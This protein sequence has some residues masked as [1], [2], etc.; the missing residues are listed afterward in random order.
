MLVALAAR[1]PAAPKPPEP[2]RIELRAADGVPLAGFW[3]DCHEPGAPAVL[4][5]HN[6]GTDHHAFRPLWVSLLHQGYHVLTLDL[7]GH[8][9]SRKLWPGA[10]DR[11]VLRD[12]RV[13]GEMVLDAE[14]AIQFLTDVQKI[15]PQKIAIVGAELGAGIGFQVMRRNTRLRGMV[16]LSPASSAY[17]LATLEDARQYGK[18][19]LLVITTKR[20]LEDGP[21]QILAALA[22]NP[23]A[24]IAVYPGGDVRGVRLL[25]QPNNVEKAIGLW[26]DRVFGRG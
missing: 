3:L 24:D 22:A 26:L 4:L 11:L 12:L 23:Q 2:N 7:R 6:A 25:G 20:L 18:R 5:L 16:A 8:G 1:A 14:A 10:Y 19:P 17:G 9:A 13:Y 21:Q 15:P